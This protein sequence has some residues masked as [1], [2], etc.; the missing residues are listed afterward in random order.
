VDT[1]P[2][3]KHQKRKLYLDEGEK[4]AK[5]QSYGKRV[6]TPVRFYT[7][8]RDIG[9]VKEN[10]PCQTA[11]PAGTN[12]PAYIRMIVEERYGRSYEVNRLANVLPGVLGDLQSAV[13]AGV[14]AWLARQRRTGQYLSPQACRGG[15]E[16]RGPPYQ[17]KP[18]HPVR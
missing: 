7:D 12:V 4:F 18:L 1:H 6:V 15:S 3:S 2:G 9:W 11:C 17:R 14:P 8:P 16:N 5:R 10:V 13:R